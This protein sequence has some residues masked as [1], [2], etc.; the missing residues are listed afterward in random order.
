MEE[1]EESK[2]EKTYDH[3]FNRVLGLINFGWKKKVK[4]TA[5]EPGWIA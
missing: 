1:K 3:F 5:E 4:D 2:R